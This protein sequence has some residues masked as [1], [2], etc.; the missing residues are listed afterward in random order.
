MM[1]RALTSMRLPTL[2]D[3]GCAAWKNASSSWADG[4]DPSYPAA[5]QA[6]LEPGTV[7]L[8]RADRPTT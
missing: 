1:G 4:W 7:F 3:W 2:A 5:P 6:R 8:T